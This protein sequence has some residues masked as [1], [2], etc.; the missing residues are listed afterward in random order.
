[1]EN[2]KKV[3]ILHSVA[4]ACNILVVTT[5]VYAICEMLVGNQAG[6]MNLGVKTF[7]YFTNLSNILVAVMTMFVLPFNINSIKSGKNELPVWTM[8]CQYVGTASV[9]VT[10]LTVILFLGPMQGYPI[11]FAGPCIFLHCITPILAIVSTCVLAT[12]DKMKFRYTFCGLIPSLLYSIAYMIAVLGTKTWD[13]YYGFTFGGKMWTVPLS[14]I[15]TQLATY[16]FSVGLWA[17]QNLMHDVFFDRAD[18]KKSLKQRREERMEKRI[19]LIKD[20]DDVEKEVSEIACTQAIED[21][22]QA[23]ACDTQDEQ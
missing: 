7:R 12:F 13:D 8:I 15:G 22:E 3:R 21:T 19:M 16:I 10:F 9:T 2:T 5:V 6:N 17:L 14:L 18:L 4:L 11:M 20:V 1:M 23:I